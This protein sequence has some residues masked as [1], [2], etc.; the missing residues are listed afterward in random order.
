MTG[1]PASPQ[2]P[3]IPTTSSR[4][5]LLWR[6][7]GS[8]GV[9][10]LSPPFGARVSADVGT[11]GD[12]RA[13]TCSPHHAAFVSPALLSRRWPARLPWDP[14]AICQP[15][16]YPGLWAAPV[17]T[18]SHPFRKSA[19]TDGSLRPAERH[20]GPLPASPVPHVA[21][22]RIAVPLRRVRL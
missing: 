14:K 10:S 2:R 11:E 21:A 19:H 20:P 4:P 9:L 22:G 5:S 12:R 13:G 16:V 3:T 8:A 18:M 6:T 1:L 7:R 15:Y 17:W